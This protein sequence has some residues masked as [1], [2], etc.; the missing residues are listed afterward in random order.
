MSTSSIDLSAGLAPKGIDL[1]AG[2]TPVAPQAL[3]LNNRLG[4]GTYQMTGQSGETVSVPYAQVQQA[5]QMGYGFADDANRFRYSKDNAADPN[6]ATNFS[7]AAGDPRGSVGYQQQMEQS[8]PLPLQVVG[9]IAKGGGT[10]ARPALDAMDYA[11]TGNTQDVGSMLEARTPAEK[12]GKYGT[13]A[14]AAAPAVVAAPVATVGGIAGGALGAG[15]G[16][17]IG[18]ATDMSPGAADLL[19]DTL[20]LAGGAG[21]AVSARPLVGALDFDAQKQAA[22][23]L[24]QSVAGD[25]NKVPVQ[26]D[27]SSDP[28]LRLMDWQKKT[29]LGPTVNKF[30][31][32]ITNP[33]QGPLTYEDARDFYQL[34]GKMSVDENNNLAPAVRRD[35]TKLVVGLKSDIGDAAE[36]VGRGADYYQGLGDYARAAK[37]QDWYDSAKDALAG[38]VVKGAAYGIGGAAAGG[39]AYKVWQFL[40][41][42]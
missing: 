14:A 7:P 16:Q 21:G 38:P 20:G 40:T 19:S 41:G 25:A 35:V 12:V 32:R 31:N 13:I 10:L 33:N 4:Q 36:T 28:A 30:L 29:N 24:L 1:S 39:V 18:K 37:Y 22:G 15:A 11:A 2:M 5:A 8:A 34:L 6:R 42:K 27:A 17:L 3:D 23:S 26:L 9:G